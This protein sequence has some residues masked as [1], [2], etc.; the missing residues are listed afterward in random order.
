M[1]AVRRAAAVASLTLAAVACG[2]WAEDP[3]ERVGRAADHRTVTPVNQLVTPEGAQL[4]LPGL[5]PQALAASPDGRL[6]VTSGKTNELVVIDAASGTVA[7]RVRPPADDIRQPP[8][9]TS[10]RN[11]APDTG[12]LQSFTGLV[13]APDGGRV[14][15]SNVQGS[16][17]VFA[18]DAAGVRPS[19]AIPLPDA[20]APRRKREIPTGLAV[21]AD[22][23]LL[24]V[25]GNLS[26]R[27][28]EIDVDSGAVLRTFDVGVA[29]YDVVLA[30]GRAF[31][32]NQGGRRPGAD[33]LTGPAG[34]GTRVRVDPR[35]HVAS[36]GSVCIVDLATATVT[37]TLV[38]RH[39]SDLAVAPDGRHVVCANAADDTLSILD[40][41]DGSL[42]ETVWTKRTPAELF[43]ATPTALAF[44]ADGRRLFVCNAAQ[45]A[46]AV[47]HW[48]PD[49]RG[50]TRL[51]GLVPVG[52]YPAALV[53]DAARERLV[54]ANMKGLPPPPPADDT[55]G[56][57][58]HQHHGSLSFVPLPDAET[59]PASSDR[60]ARNLRAERIRAALLPPRAD[61]PPRAIP[62]RI[63][64]PSLIEHVVYVIKENRTYDQVLGDVPAGRGRPD[65]C[66][67][68]ADVTPNQHALAAR[69]VLLDNTYCCGILSADGHNWSTSAATTDYLERSFG[70]FPRSYP[71][72]MEDDDA[73]A[74]AWSP[75]GFIWDSAVRQ[76][77]SVRNYGEFMMPRVRW[78]EAGRRGAPDFRACYAAWRADPD[79]R[80]VVFG[81]EPAIE[82]IREF[83][84]AATV[85]WNMSVPDQ[86]RADFVLAELAD[87][88]REGR[89]PNLVII[90]LPN[91]H[92]SGTTP[93]APTPAA[94]VADNDLAFGRIVAGLSR[95]RFW[96]KMAVFAIE[97]DPQAGWDHVSGF[98]T[99]AYV[100]SP[101]ARRG[102]VVSTQYN[103]TSI[104]RT[105]GQ[106]LGLPP[107]NQFDASAE[108]MSDCFTDE[109]D[110]TPFD[111]LPATVPLDQLN[112]DP[113]AILDPLRRAR[114]VASAAIDFLEVD[115]APEDLLNRILWGERKGDEPYPEWA[116]SPD[117]DED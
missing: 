2:A 28:F 66:I 68:G 33:D 87:F 101:Y 116:V 34:R 71:D 27:L 24:Y 20:A 63:G 16:V 88:E 107:M 48:D 14:Y 67:F 97:D 43:G 114:A 4:D 56:F 7:G 36:E 62:E 5:R 58:S 17:K 111:V 81:S 72:G 46:V 89:Y 13:F 18:V 94:C 25:C 37:E 47:L 80:E 21:S 69:Y 117:G 19:H 60:V 42:V 8:A 53:V 79:R 23:R 86:F 104:L 77:R 92:T 99:T 51:E 44:A 76:G 82:S 109:A 85:G 70:G 1:I 55:R 22:G 106:I 30:G 3:Q 50:E 73:D 57:N 100:A 65:L 31:V 113:K 39:A 54:V 12:A 26:N 35:T 105:I 61:V 96:P 49:E 110:P 75:A 103:T 41:R 29:P 9:D 112:P 38:G 95:S 6:L 102:A 115:R 108:P 90:C 64:E 78:A 59:L 52:W 11:L 74:L 15:M 93:G 98:R 84:P 32:S 10:D 83:S 45:N 40:A 91:D